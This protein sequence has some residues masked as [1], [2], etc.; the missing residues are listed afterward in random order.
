VCDIRWLDPVAPAT[1]RREV[2]VVGRI[3][4]DLVPADRPAEDDAQR[5][6]GVRDG[7]G[8]E[9]GV[10][11]VGPDRR[12]TRVRRTSS[13]GIRQQAQNAISRGRA[14]QGEPGKGIRELRPRAGRSPWRPIYRRVSPWRFVILAVAPEA[15][16][17]SRG[18][19]VAVV[20]AAERFGELEV[21]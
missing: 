6:E 4:R 3:D 2:E 1:D 20:R 13:C 5:I 16:I 7:R 15:Q 18:Y 14:V 12:Q 10:V 17:D 8:G 9:A 11:V 19:D 21:D